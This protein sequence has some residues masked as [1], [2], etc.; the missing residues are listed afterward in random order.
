[1]TFILK[2]NLENKIKILKLND[3]YLNDNEKTQQSY[4]IKLQNEFY[5]NNIEEFKNLLKNLA[6]TQKYGFKLISFKNF[7]DFNEF[8]GLKRQFSD[9]NIDVS[10]FKM[11]HNDENEIILRVYEKI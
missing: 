2:S 6:I 1:M 10:E 7:K 8:L 4:L 11:S 9:A 3:T 5:V